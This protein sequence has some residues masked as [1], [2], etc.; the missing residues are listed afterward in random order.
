MKVQE[1]QGGALIVT[2][3]K[4]IAEAMGIKKGEDITFKLD[5]SRLYLER[6]L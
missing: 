3:P 1:L 4:A 6:V 5:G 2:I